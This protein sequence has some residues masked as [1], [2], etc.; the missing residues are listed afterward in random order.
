MTILTRFGVAWVVATGIVF[1]LAL[2]AGAGGDAAPPGQF[3]RWLWGAMELAA[4]PA[5]IVVSGAAIR[6]RGPLLV[7]A[8]ATLAAAAFVFLLSAYLGPALV[9]DV[10]TD[11]STWVHPDRVAALG[12]A[13]EAAESSGSLVDW[14]WANVLGWSV[15]RPITAALSTGAFAWIGA[16]LAAWIPTA[17]SPRAR[18]AVVAGGGLF[19][20]M[21]GY[22]MMENGYEQLLLRTVGPAAVTAWFP[23]ISPGMLAVG[24]AVPTLVRL[25]ERGTGADLDA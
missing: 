22:L 23:L 20:L 4:F 15:E 11:P 8:G 13:L 24:L 2:L 21:T 18:F 5:G 9:A 17:W 1:T 19:L 16:L 10:Q 25:S 3:M 14:Q 12:A 6:W 7:F